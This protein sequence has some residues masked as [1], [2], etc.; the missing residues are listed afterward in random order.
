MRNATHWTFFLFFQAFL[1]PFA[2]GQRQLSPAQ[3]TEFLNAFKNGDEY[4]AKKK[5]EKAKKA[6]ERAIELKPDLSAPYRRLGVVF[7][8]MN[9]FSLAAEY[10]EKSIEVNPKS[11]RA[12]YFQAGEMLMRTEQYGKAKARLKEYQSFLELPP[13]AF[14][15]G[16]TELETEAYYNTLLESY[17]ANCTFSAHKIDFENVDFKNLGPKINSTLD[18]LFPYISNNETWMFYTRNV[19]LAEEDQLMYSTAEGT[20]WAKSKAL[21]NKKM[22]QDFN[23]GMG[24]ISRD[25]TVMYFPGCNLEN[26]RDCEIM[27]ANMKKDAILGINPL[28]D[29][30]N[31]TYRESQPT[32]NCEGKSLYFVSN[33]PGGYGGMD[34]YVSHLLNDGTWTKA[35]NLG[36]TINSSMDEE[37]PFIA[38]DNVT[39]FFASNGHPGFGGTDIFYSRFNED[40]GIWSKPQNMGKPVNSPEHEI[41]FFMNARGNKGYIAS[42]REGGFGGL[43]I[44]E[45]NMPPKKDFEEI[46]YVRGR[47]LDAVTQKP[48]ESVVYIGDKGNYATDEEGRFFVC[49]PTLSKLNVLVSERKYYDFEEAF[50]LTNWN[51]EGFVEID[52]YLRPLSQALDIAT[53]NPKVVPESANKIPEILAVDPELIKGN[54]LPT[55]KIYTTENV[56]FY[57]DDFTLTQEAR[58]AIDRLIDDIDEDQLALIV[59]EGFADH[60]GTDDY[61]QKLSEKRAEEV[62]S[63]LKAKGY[64]NLRIKYKGYGETN[65]SFIYAKNRKVDIHVYYKI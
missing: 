29:E 63:Y 53:I 1:L 27:K 5:L 21:L 37:S 22:R 16:E 14:D 24:K 2:F 47:V 28:G 20:G 4:L 55:E 41:S 36:P 26:G 65:A 51:S 8:L 3:Q 19:P 46:A 42:S 56:H 40:E 48:I 38:D 13:E 11:S 59:V 23:Q 10:F 58:L 49:H 60:I 54:K 17:L 61:N 52:I 32:V 34:I 57:F 31:S 12:L 39:L 50:E 18:D 6:Y 44:Y 45:F 30:I 43:D 7:E 15:N 25:E 9:N 62:A 35:M 64:T 33:R